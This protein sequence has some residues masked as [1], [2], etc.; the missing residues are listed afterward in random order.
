MLITPISKDAPHFEKQGR[1]YVYRYGYKTLEDDTV[2][3]CVEESAT[4]LSLETIRAR[5]LSYN[6][7][8]NINETF[9]ATAYGF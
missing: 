5:V 1:I 9:D 7:S 3:A 6:S 8:N 4:K 2:I